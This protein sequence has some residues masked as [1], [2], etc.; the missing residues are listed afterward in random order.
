VETPSAEDVRKR[1]ELLRDEFPEG[2]GDEAL[3]LLLD[4]DAPVISALTGRK[5]GPPDTP[6]EEVPNWLRPTA[7]RAFAMR[8]ERGALQGSAEERESAI[9]DANIRSETYGPIS[10]SYFG[11][12]EASSAKVLDPD[13]AV[14]ELLWALATDRMKDYW[15][16]LWG[17]KTPGPWM[18]VVE[19][20]WGRRQRRRRGY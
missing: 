2:A 15:L 12:G 9:G 1:S 8:A 14:H 6:G 10:L 18:N 19:F 11:P 5:I 17:Q 16:V 13:P 20:D 7:I 3:K 4:D